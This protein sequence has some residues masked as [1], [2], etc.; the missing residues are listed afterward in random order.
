MSQWSYATFV[1]KMAHFKSPYTFITKLSPENSV[2]Q[3]AFFQL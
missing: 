1:A 3:L 2:M